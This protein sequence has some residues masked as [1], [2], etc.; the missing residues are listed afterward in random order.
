MVACTCVV[1]AYTIGLVAATT[2]RTRCVANVW[3]S[4]DWESD[5]EPVCFPLAEAMSVREMLRW[6]M[7]PVL[8]LVILCLRWN[9]KFYGPGVVTSLF[10]EY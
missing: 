3:L 2:T 9:G 8:I 6:H 5:L 4:S 1:Y 7:P 10:F